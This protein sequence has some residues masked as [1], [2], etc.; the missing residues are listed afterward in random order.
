[1]SLNFT[2]GPE[3]ELNWMEMLNY[4]VGCCFPGLIITNP[5]S[6]I[7][8]EDVGELCAGCCLFPALFFVFSGE[9]I[10]Q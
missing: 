7:H 10:S 2:L 8:Q 9:L 4:A 1:M 5:F 6:E 3:N